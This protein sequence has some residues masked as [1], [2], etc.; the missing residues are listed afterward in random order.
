MKNY[1]KGL[2]KEMIPVLLGV[3]LAL[4]INNWNENRKDRKYINNFYL[5]LKKEFRDTDEE[6]TK[7]LP[8]Q[9]VLLDTL[10]VYKNDETI[11]LLEVVEKANG[12]NGPNIKLN[13]WKA[14]SNSKIELLEYNRL[15]ILAD[16]EKAMNF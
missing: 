1:L 10:E 12:V 8:Y 4:W 9:K 14:L 7:K 6:I 16:I 2:I 13:Y 3:L 15:S 11:S 5:S